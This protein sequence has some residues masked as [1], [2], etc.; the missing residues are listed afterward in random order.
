M[1][2]LQTEQAKTQKSLVDFDQFSELAKSDP[3]AF[4]AKRAEV[5]EQVIERMPAHKQHRMR[6]LQWKIDQVRAQA[7]N[8]LSACIT[9]SEMM[10]DS[11]AGPGGLR[12]TLERLGNGNFEPTPKARVLD[13][14]RAP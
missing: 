1:P 10:W 14:E 6:C 8:P 9:L 13:F 11:L 7:G 12:E 4:E 5:I 3:D 2:Q